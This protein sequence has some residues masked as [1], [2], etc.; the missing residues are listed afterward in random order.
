MHRSGF[1][2]RWIIGLPWRP[3]EQP[4]CGECICTETAAARCMRCT[5]SSRVA[6][7]ATGSAHARS[8]SL[9][10]SVNVEG[11]RVNDEVPA[12]RD[13]GNEKRS[14]ETRSFLASLYIYAL[15]FAWQ[16]HVSSLHVAYIAGI[17]D[18]L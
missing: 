7:T 15:F 17:I 9:A 11:L 5:A 14:E 16:L 6:A 12:I 13:S 3:A 8:L 18:G 1:V 2:F 4:T 10:A